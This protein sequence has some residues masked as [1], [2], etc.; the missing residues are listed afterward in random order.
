MMFK[1]KNIIITGGSSGIGR[2]LALRLAK[3]GASLALVARDPERLSKTREE[4]ISRASS[5][6]PRVEFFSCDVTDDGKVRQ[7]MDKI[8]DEL[9]SPDYLFNSAG[10]IIVDYFE[11][12]HRD[13]FREIMDTNFFGTLHFIKAALPHFKKKGRGHIV[14]ISS[15]AGMIGVFGYASYCASKY[16]VVGLTETL[17]AELKLQGIAIHLVLP[18]EVNTPMLTKVNQSRPIENKMLTRIMSVLSVDQVVDTVIKGVKRGRYLIIPGRRA[19]LLGRMSQIL[20]SVAM[21]IVDHTVRKNY[22]GPGG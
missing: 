13:N 17:R 20:P 19:R 15:I 11:N 1:G 18:P 4:I 7:T 21:R 16:A 9:G 12:L 22:R 8:V 10:I 5:P 3:E 2:G 14:N 6:G